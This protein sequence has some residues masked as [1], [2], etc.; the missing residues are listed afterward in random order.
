MAAF[1]YFLKNNNKVKTKNK[2]NMLGLYINCNC[3]FPFWLMIYFKE[4]KN[5]LFEIFFI[6]IWLYL[7]K[8]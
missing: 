6:L 2:I 4:P 5:W 8:L 1:I 3:F 7:I